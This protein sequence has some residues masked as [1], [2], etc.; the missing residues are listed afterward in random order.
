MAD[1][2]GINGTRSVF[3]VV[4]K[5]N[6]PG[7]VSWAQATGVAKFGIDYVVPDMLEA[8]FLRNPYPNARIKSLDAT[9]AKAIAGVVDVITWEDPEFGSQG[10]GGGGFGRG[11]GGF[12]SDY[13]DQEGNEIGAIVV[14]E[15]ADICEE[16]LR[17]LEIEWEVLPH[18]VN[19][20]EGRKPDAPVIRPPAPAGKAGG[21]GGFGGRGGGD[22]PP[23]QGNVSYSIVNDGDIEAG[24]KEADHII[25]YDVNT[26]A[27]SGHIP[28]PTG[29][30]AW[31][32]DSPLHGEGKN[33]RIEGVPWSGIS[34]A[35]RSV[36][37]S[38]DKVFQECFFVGGRY[39]DWGS[40]KSQNI[41]PQLARR[42]GRPV[43]CVNSRYDMYDFNLNDRFVHLKV[44]YKSNGLITA[45]DDFSIAD[46]GVQGSTNFGNTM[47][48]TYGPYFTTK[49]KNVKQYMEVVDS[50]RGIM[51][52]SGQHNPMS[53]DSLMAGIHLIAGK[54]GKD[55]IEIATLNLH[56]P[57][58]QDDP[59]PV[60]SYE[61]CVAAVKKMMNWNWHA[62]G[63]RKFPDGRMH[64]ASFRYNQCPRHSGASYNPKL[65]LRN[66]VVHLES[67]GAIIGHY[68]LEANMMVIAEE[69]GLEYEDIRLHLNHHY[70][71]R[72]FGGG[73]DGSTASSWA[74][75]E[76]ANILKQK[77]LEA[78][79]EEA[80]NPSSGGGGF[81]RKQQQA[82][83]NPFKGLKPEDLDMA[84]G[85]VI[86]KADPEK[87]LPLGQAVRA[88]LFAT[89]SGRPPLALW[90]QQGRALDTMNVATC[91]VAVDTE[92]GEVEVL[93]FGVVADPGKVMRQTSLESQIHQVL[94]FTTGCQMLEEFI[95][96]KNTGLR[97]STNMFE[98]KKV[99]MLDMPRVE[100]ELLETQAGNACYGSN[101]ISHSLANTHLVIMA[102]QNAIGKWVDSPATP[103]KVLKALGKA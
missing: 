13:T 84:D 89:Y 17:A 40:R 26:A 14:A 73:S 9:K 72:P 63:A 19:L 33:L 87:G 95:F 93:R 45:I 91:E 10:G 55:P 78:A 49:C 90:N 43:R 34:G 86:V 36:G 66:G 75:K 38:S 11:G 97:L 27:F 21:F 3:R 30:V 35:A 47:D 80:E 53:W 92:T 74:I 59:N 70:T 7:V 15:N 54:L 98:Y 56:G 46:G 83:P 58:S 61:A 12:I 68:G 8:K 81:G 48:Q 42:Y 102:I 96:D 16:A 28:N 20:L 31:F 71:Y 51:R 24:F 50:N 101:G 18:V 52:T 82:A 77:I 88:N 37:L 39:C 2:E 1:L 60:P 41:T 65:E 85:R 6:L 57:E 100:L 94:D 44:G 69:L 103:D 32:F 23:K 76:C 25:E 5:P 79:I 67:C 4:G 29:T 22:N 99:G 64:G 62:A